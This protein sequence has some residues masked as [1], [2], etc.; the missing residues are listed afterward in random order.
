[1]SRSSTTA[2][3][4][5][6]AYLPGIITPNGGLLRHGTRRYTGAYAA[7]EPAVACRRTSREISQRD[8]W[9]YAT[10]NTAL[11]HGVGSRSQT[12]GYP[13]SRRP[14]HSRRFSHLTM[15]GE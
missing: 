9:T 13:A 3:L 7:P 14:T 15:D 1:M 8:L 12:F 11:L 5:A 4:Y 10:V 6:S 2:P